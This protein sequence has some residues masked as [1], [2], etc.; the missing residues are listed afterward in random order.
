MGIY[1]V[2][3][4]KEKELKNRM[5]ACGLCERDLEESFVRA[6]GPGGQKTN[7]SATAVHIIHKPS[8]ITVKAQTARSQA[9][10]RFYARRRLCELLER[11]LQG[12]DSVEAKEWAKL[13]KQKARRHRRS[14]LANT[15]PHS[16]DCNETTDKF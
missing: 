9:L 14:R 12:Q 13:K 3:P 1:G 11:D 15:Q 6:S 16:I 2:T 4:E 5:T 10:N 8:G 7:K